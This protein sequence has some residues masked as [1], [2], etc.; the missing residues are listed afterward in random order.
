MARERLDKL[1]LDRGLVAS[2]ERAR[3]LIMTGGVLVRGQP[4]TKPGTLIDP[5][6][7]ITLRV[8]DHP[9]VSRG[10]LKLVQ[11]LDSFGVDPA[12]ATAL[13]IGASTGGFSD[14]LLRRG[15]VRVYAIDVGYGQLAWSIRQDPRV[16]VLE[17]VNVRTIDLALVPEACDLAVIDVSFISLTMVLPRVRALLQPPVGKPI[18][19][20]V[21]PQFEVGRERVGKGGV[22]RDPEARRGAVDK[23]RSW[24]DANGFVA[25]PDVE[26]P[27]TGPAGNVEYLLLLRT[28]D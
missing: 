24:A 18:V 16:V 17:R 7:E 12:G 10:A 1:L 19:A 13:D 21:K 6:V 5:A 25:G 4:E 23:V 2:R 14:V 28:A 3:S 20:L 26:S 15:A 11:G 9:Y 8:E 27:I 22:V